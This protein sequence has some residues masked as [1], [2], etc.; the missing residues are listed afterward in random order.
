[1]ARPNVG[2]T[3]QEAEDARTGFAGKG[4]PSIVASQSL[5]DQG[6]RTRVSIT[7]PVGDQGDKATREE[8][9]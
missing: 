8:D 1:M 7:E 5:A 4:N 6:P 2:R 9:V 3:R